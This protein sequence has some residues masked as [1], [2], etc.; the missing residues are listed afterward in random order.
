MAKV[1]R[2]SI[3]R[4]ATEMFLE[5]G[6]SATSPGMISKAL[7]ISTGNLTYH[8]P[9][10]EHLLSELVDMLCKYQWALME[11]E[12]AEGYSSIMA[13][14]LELATMNA[15]CETDGVAKDFFLS[16]YTSLICMSIIRKNDTERAKKVFKE[17]RSDWTHEQF[18]EAEILVS[19]IEY[20]TLM[21]A[22]DPVA[23]ETRISGALHNILGIYGIP[24]E[25]RNQK[26]QKVLAMDYRSLGKRVLDEFREF[27]KTENDHALQNLLK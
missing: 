19:G 27:V 7:D 8:F 18:A 10:K 9:T 2:L 11:Q 17:Y 15:A 26:L 20:A 14:C 24:E 5:R 12:A 22:G 16:A 23:L 25:I 13:I 6:Y 3:V 1:T 4:C 21:T